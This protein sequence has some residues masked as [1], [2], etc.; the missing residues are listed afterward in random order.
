MQYEALY[1]NISILQFAVISIICLSFRN[2]RVYIFFFLKK[3]L[4]SETILMKFKTVK[5]D[6]VDM[7]CSHGYV[8]Q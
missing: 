4:F 1:H 2:L 8:S 6:P 3:H 7:T 5:C